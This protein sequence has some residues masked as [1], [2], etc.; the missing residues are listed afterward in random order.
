MNKVRNPLA[1]ADQVLEH[2]VYGTASTV[3]DVVETNSLLQSQETDVCADA[4]YQGARKRPDEKSDVPR[5]IAMHPWL[6]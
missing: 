4:G 3:N 6:T 2:T 1:L 5:H